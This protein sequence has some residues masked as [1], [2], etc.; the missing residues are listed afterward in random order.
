MVTGAL[1][2]DKNP[3]VDHSKKEKI[4]FSGKGIQYKETFTERKLVIFDL[5]EENY[6]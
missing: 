4:Y 2:K 3:I 1:E 6:R 5:S